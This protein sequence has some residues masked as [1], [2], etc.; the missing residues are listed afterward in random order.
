M[1]AVRH[2]AHAVRAGTP[3]TTKLRGNQINRAGL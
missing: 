2:V 3:I 1:S